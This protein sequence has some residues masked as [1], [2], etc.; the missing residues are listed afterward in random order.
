MTESLLRT[1]Y[2]EQN[3]VIPYMKLTKDEK[4]KCNI[5]IF[6]FKLNLKKQKIKITLLNKTQTNAGNVSEHGEESK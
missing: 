1:D 3:C 5:F 4:N 2:T 6:F